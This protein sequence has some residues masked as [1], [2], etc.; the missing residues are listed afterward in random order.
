MNG[1]LA[2]KCCCNVCRWR[3][4]STKLVQENDY[5]RTE[6]TSSFP[7]GKQPETA[8]KEETKLIIGI[9]VTC[10]LI[11]STVKEDEV[12][13]EGRPVGQTACSP[14]RNNLTVKSVSIISASFE[15][16]PVDRQPRSSQRCISG[17]GNSCNRLFPL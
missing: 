1:S 2:V 4:A 8:N 10:W 17:Q 13:G 14:F 9:C 6:Y 11:L 15:V 16:M 7:S 12:F 5:R 3:S